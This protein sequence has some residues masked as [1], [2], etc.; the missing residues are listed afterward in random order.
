MK[1]NQAAA[2]AAVLSAA[3]ASSSAASSSAHDELKDKIARS[4]HYPDFFPTEKRSS[5]FKPTPFIPKSS[6]ALCSAQISV[7]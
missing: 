6:A 2:A 5:L 4:I 1:L 3:L 7:K